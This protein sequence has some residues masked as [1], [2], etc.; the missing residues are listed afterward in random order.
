[1]KLPGISGLESL[2]I[3][4]ALLPGLLTLIVVRYLCGR[5]KKPEAV[6]ATLHA[7]AYTLV[8]HGIWAILK[9]LG[10]WFPM[11]DI[12]GLSLCA[13][14][15]GVVVAW[16]SNNGQAHAVIARCGLTSEAP[17]AT[18]WESAFRAFRRDGGEYVVL[19]LKDGKR[20]LGALRAYSGQQKEGHV[21]IDR[22]RWLGTDGGSEPEQPGMLAF[23]AEAI[24]SIQFM[25]LVKGSSD[26][27]VTDSTT[28]AAPTTAERTQGRLA[29]ASE[30]TAA[31]ATTA[32]AGAA[33]E[34]VAQVATSPVAPE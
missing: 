7:L 30:D 17:W 33:T 29:T 8:V 16:I 34:E 26:A 21:C 18:V 20:I 28:S 12:A 5:D 25:P 27:R 19:T 10:S 9:S 3:L 32:T 22:A 1:M 2:G 4:S 23:S 24:E 6:E 13:I 14:G 31:A 15:L 11:P